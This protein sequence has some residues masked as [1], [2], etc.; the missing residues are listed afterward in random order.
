MAA[1]TRPLNLSE[2]NITK[3]RY[4]ELRW[5]CRQ[6]DKKKRDAAALLTVRISTPAPVTIYKDKREYGEFM[7]RG[8]GGVSDPTAQ[9]AEKR[10]RLLRDVQVIERAARM[11][12][13]E[14]APYILKA[15]TGNDGIERVIANT[16]APLSYGD[17]RT[18]RRRF[19]YILDGLLNGEIR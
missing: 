13:D 15:V 16:K 2:Y 19:F 11:A 14:M 3:E 4:N 10:D 12:A 18:L 9:T 5:F 8:G 6:Y 17:F 1:S 7:P